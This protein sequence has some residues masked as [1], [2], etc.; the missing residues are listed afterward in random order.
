LIKKIPGL[1]TIA[2][3]DLLGNVI[4]SIYWIFLAI[5][6]GPENYGSVSYFISIASLASTI[7]LFG[8]PQ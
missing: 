3:G 5:V 4:S 1:F 7:S 2:F 8:I 6:I